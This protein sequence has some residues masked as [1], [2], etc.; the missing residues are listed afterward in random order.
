MI[1]TKQLFKWTFLA[2][3]FFL[4]IESNAQ[5]YKGT[6][7]WS[8]VGDRG[9]SPNW[10]YSPMLE[11][12]SEGK[13]LI[14]Y[15]DPQ[16]KD[17]IIK[18][19]DG[20]SWNVLS[21]S[22]TNGIA[23]KE[24]SMGMDASD[25]IYLA[26]NFDDSLSVMKYVGGA[27]TY[28]GAM[29]FTAGEQPELL[30]TPS[31]VLYL[32]FIRYS[33]SMVMKYDGSW[34]IIGPS[35]FADDSPWMIGITMA[36]N[37][38]YFAAKEGGFS[39]AQLGVYHYTGQ[40]WNKLEDTSL[41]KNHYNFSL[42][43]HSSG[44]LFLA[45]RDITDSSKLSVRQWTGTGWKLMGLKGM[46]NDY[47]YQLDMALK[48]DGNPLIAT[49]EG[50]SNVIR[51]FDWDGSSWTDLSPAPL[52]TSNWF[53]G[54]GAQIKMDQNDLAYMAMQ[55]KGMVGQISV[56]VHR[57]SAH[58]KDLTDDYRVFIG[59]NPSYG[60]LFIER[61]NSNTVLNWTMRDLS[62]KKLIEGLMHE[63][64]FKSRIEL[65]SYCKGGLYFLELQHGHF[66]RISR[67]V[68]SAP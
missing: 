49:V 38:V 12:D 14:A 68:I 31:G 16:T 45:Y 41:Q 8:A 24:I 62:G 20:S 15:I 5:I 42:K 34:E 7:P 13:A 55:D 53:T 4:G 46:G 11:I 19:W 52:G 26:V 17:A 36:G 57:A 60:K 18:R 59:P 1:S 10:T 29:N 47:V 64:E 33:E 40:A 44:K 39:N 23:V 66:H 22:A 63:G 2:L 50:N 56:F 9:L 35:G 21:P 37:D 27:W 67:I 65:S 28:L 32:A 43:G 54:S 3:G 51:V 58:I 48:S 30:V 25:A 6:E 61:E